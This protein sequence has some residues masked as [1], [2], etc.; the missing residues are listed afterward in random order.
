MSTLPD[1]VVP[2]SLYDEAYYLQWCIGYEEWRRSGGV[3]IAERYPSSLRIAG[4]APGEVVVDV[5]TGRAE[6]L[7]AALRL[8]AARAVGLEYSPDA[9]RLARRTLDAAQ[10]QE[11]L[12]RA[13]VLLADAR[14][15][16]LP[17]R[18]VD[19]VTMLDVVEHLAPRELERT[20]SETRRVLRPG[21][22]VFIHTAPNRHL[23]ETVYRLQR[24]AV[25]G[26]AGRWPENPRNH[27][28]RTMHVNEQTRGSLRRTLRRAGFA[29]V[30]AWLGEWLHTEFLPAEARA[31]S[32]AFILYHRL[33]AHRAT[34]W[35]VMCDVWAQGRR[36]D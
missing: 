32:R 20:L 12:P 10:E 31:P 14:A 8:G 34:R 24:R 26:R 3:E 15:M 28:E 5:G 23:Y 7:V 36:P 29:Q 27:H 2:A 17:D 25:P 1:P 33:A 18:S 30:H 16:P 4:L 21:G 13:E 19:L 35:L 9:V 6:L 11:S 22:R